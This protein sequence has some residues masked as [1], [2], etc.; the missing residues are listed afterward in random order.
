[1]SKGRSCM[2]GLN[3]KPHDDFYFPVIFPHLPGALK[4]Y[5]LPTTTLRCPIGTVSAAV[6]RIDVC[7]CI[8]EWADVVHC[9]LLVT[10]TSGVHSFDGYLRK[11]S[12][13]CGAS[14]APAIIIG[15]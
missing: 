10:D 6:V 7:G 2:P 12:R 14:Y 3:L 1:M 5:R 11:M 13:V 8:P 15:R 9:E 4:R